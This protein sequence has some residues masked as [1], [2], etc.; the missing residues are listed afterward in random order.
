MLV[1][2]LGAY[3]FPGEAPAST[4]TIGEPGGNGGGATPAALTD[5]LNTVSRAAADA[6]VSNRL[7]FF[8]FIVDL[9]SSFSRNTE[10]LERSRRRDFSS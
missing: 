1:G 5:A 10:R 6:H 4:L 9:L 7:R 8:V 3:G 2:A